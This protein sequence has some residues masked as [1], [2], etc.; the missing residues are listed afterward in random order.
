MIIDRIRTTMMPPKLEA[1]T[2]QD[3][4][5]LSTQLLEHGEDPS[6]VQQLI[7]IFNLTKNQSL[8]TDEEWNQ[9]ME[10]WE[11]A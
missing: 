11:Q 8:E 7:S 9:F 1:N 6:L 2:N 4:F 5:N 3:I 10:I